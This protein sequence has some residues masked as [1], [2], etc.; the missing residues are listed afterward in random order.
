MNFIPLEALM[1]LKKFV[2][3]LTQFLV[4]AVFSLVSPGQ[5]FP[6]KP[7]IFALPAAPTERQ[8]KDRNLRWIKTGNDFDQGIYRNAEEIDKEIE[9]RIKAYDRETAIVT[10]DVPINYSRL[11]YEKYQK[12]TEFNP[13]IGNLNL[14]GSGQPLDKKAHFWR[15]G[16]IYIAVEGDSY[17]DQLNV[18]SIARAVEILKYRYPEA[19]QKL[20]IE[21]GNFK[22]KNLSY[23]RWKNKYAVLLFSFDESPS[24]IAGG[25]TANGKKANNTY[26]DNNGIGEYSNVSVVSIDSVNIEGKND[27]GSKPIYRSGAEEN[28]MR[29]LREGLVETLVH[30][31]IHRYID[32]MNSYDE[33]FNKI[34]NLRYDENYPLDS[35]I[36]GEEVIVT[37][38]SLHYFQKKGGLQSSIPFYYG[39]DMMVSLEKLKQSSS[40]TNAYLQIT[41]PQ[42]NFSIYK[43]RLSL[44][45]F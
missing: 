37:T 3:S 14:S 7:V 26:F 33:S 34:F 45:L 24:H 6:P 5:T 43:D 38:T 17:K 42:N 20:F 32:Y 28:Y 9:K 36:S 22:G 10:F 40:L 2:L 1:K 31:M 19:Y 11:L 8:L 13:D 30:E 16:N 39:M 35:R 44:G 29:Y 21:V 15:Y 4:I 41:D 27:S 18:Y 23:A 25:I 12:Y